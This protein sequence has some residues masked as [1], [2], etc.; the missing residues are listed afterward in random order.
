VVCHEL[1]TRRDTRQENNAEGIRQ[2]E[3]AH[4]KDAIYGK[5]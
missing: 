5:Q 1:Q 2:K 4:R 3:E